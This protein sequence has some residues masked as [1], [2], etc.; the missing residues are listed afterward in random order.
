M[1]PDNN[2]IG[3]GSNISPDKN[4]HR[5]KTSK[6]TFDKLDNE[7]LYKKTTIPKQSKCSP[8]HK[9]KKSAKDNS[10]LHSQCNDDSKSRGFSFP[11]EH[12]TTNNVKRPKGK[13]PSIKSPKGRIPTTNS[14]YYSSR[15]NR[16]FYLLLFSLFL[17]Q[18]NNERNPK[19]HSVCMEKW[20][21][22]PFSHQNILSIFSSQDIN[23]FFSK[24][25]SYTGTNTNWS[26]VVDSN[27]LQHSVNGNRRTIGYKLGMWNCGRG[28]L[29]ETGNKLVDMHRY[30][31]KYKPHLF[32][33]IEADLHGPQSR[34]HRQ[35]TFTT[36]E[37]HEKLEIPGYS[38]ILP[39]TWKC[40]DQARLIVFV[41]DEIKAVIVPQAIQYNDL[42]TVTLVIGMGRAKKTRVNLSLIHI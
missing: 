27:F 17:T 11:N 9:S 24:Y 23:P 35:K 38:L 10:N 28:L 22:I 2:Q 41:N 7:K 34:I 29:S 25:P 3:Y 20:Y 37:L 12:S 39:D 16:M 13:I 31:E 15:I 30:I 36:E 18:H 21:Q 32:C 19:Q 42:P 5:N 4:I 26:Y 33:I 40:H 1:R 6:P 14:K 8:D